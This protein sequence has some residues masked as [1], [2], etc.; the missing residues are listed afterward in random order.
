LSDNEELVFHLKQQQLIELIRKGDV[1]AALEFAQRELASLGQ[2]NV[3]TSA[4]LVAAHRLRLTQLHAA[5]T[6]T[7]TLAQPH[8][9]GELE[10]TMALLAFD[11]NSTSSPVASLLETRQR[12]ALTFASCP[13]VR[14][15][16]PAGDEDEPLGLQL[17]VSLC[18]RRLKVASE[19]NAA[20]LINQG[21]DKGMSAFAGRVR[22]QHQHRRRRRC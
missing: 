4:L 8:F 11:V 18:E 5:A 16:L 7:N 1:D 19:A 14:V 22:A 20:L 9:L 3:R 15:S 21:Q 13:L 12:Y 17:T 6:T 10:R 2:E